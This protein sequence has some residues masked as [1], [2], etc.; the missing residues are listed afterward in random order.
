[1]IVVMKPAATE[2]DVQAIIDR[3]EG[4]GCKTHVIVGTDQTVIGVI[5]DGR[6]H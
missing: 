3:V 1:M 6:S 5:G 2:E 4:V